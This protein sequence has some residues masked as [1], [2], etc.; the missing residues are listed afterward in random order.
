MMTKP[1]ILLGSLT[2]LAGGC[3]TMSTYDPYLLELNPPYW[4]GAAIQTPPHDFNL[5]LS[6]GELARLS[7]TSGPLPIRAEAR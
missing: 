5:F 3:A 1:L 2:V 6:G 4:E 7:S